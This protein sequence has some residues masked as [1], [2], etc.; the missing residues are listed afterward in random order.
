M[1]R[2]I[3]LGLFVAL[4]TVFTSLFAS[5]R[6]T[7]SKVNFDRDIRPILERSCYGCH[8]PAKAMSQLRLNDRSSGMRVI[9]PGNAKTSRLMARILGEGGEVQMPLGGPA[10]S[11]TDIELIRN[12]IDQ[13]ADWP[14]SPA[15]KKHWSFNAPTRD[16]LPAV[17]DR[18]WVKNPIDNFVLAKIE[19]HGLAPSPE[20]DRITLIR[21]LSLDL[22]GLPP[23]LEE[24]DRF[25]SDQDAK[26]YENLVERLLASPHYGERWGRHWL[27]VARYAD[28][29]GFEK[30]L[31]RSIWP[32]RDWVV[33]A[34]NRDMPFDQFTIEQLAGDL[35]PAPT[36][37]QR[38]AT[39]FLRNSMLNEEGAV[40][41]EQF[42]V[43]G[44]IDRVDAIGKAFLGLTINCAQCH[45]HK[46][47][48]IPQSDYYR[49]YAFLNSDDEPTLEVADPEVL[50]TRKEILD[51]IDKVQSDLLTSRPEVAAQFAG[52]EKSQ[53]QD[54]SSWTTIEDAS[55]TASFGTK[56]DRPPD[57]S[58]VAKGDNSTKNVY[59]I[60]ALSPL[61]RVT[62][63]RLELLT[64]P[65][66][67]RGGPGR[68]REGRLY[69]T[70]F[71]LDA[72]PADKASAAE[73]VAWES[74]TADFAGTSIADA[75]DGN[76]DTAWN[77][78]AGPGRRNQTRKAVF[79][80][81]RAVGFESGTNLT[82]YLSQKQEDGFNIGRFR[83]SVTDDAHPR[84]DR[85]PVAMR[86]IVSV[87]EASRSKDQKRD[88]F[89]YFLSTDE[90]YQVSSFHIDDLMKGWPYGPTT[91]VLAP[92]EVSRE[93]HIFKR[94]DW[95]RPGDVVRPGT[96]TALHPLPGGTPLNRLGLAQWIIDKQN[97]L[98]P[99]V[100][101]NRMWQEYFGVG[102]VTTPEDFGA[103]CESPS[104]PGLLDWLASEF[105][106]TGW[107]MKHIH[108]LIVS[109][110]TYRQSSKVTPRVQEADPTNVWLAR[111]PRL[112]V[113]AEIVHDIALSAG[114]LLNLKMGGPSVYPSIPDG[115]LNLG[116]GAP[117]RWETSTGAD[118][119]R[120]GMYTF[121]KRSVPYPS[122]L[123]FDEPN[124]DSSC[125]RRIRSNT[126]LQALTTLNDQ[127]F[128]EAAK[129]LGLRAWREG[130]TDDPSRV[131]YAFRLCTGRR[132]DEFEL[133]QL[134]KLL[135]EQ[136][137]YFVGKTG[138][139]VYVSAPDL[140][141]LPMDVDLHKVAPLTVVARVILNLD[142]TITRE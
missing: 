95:K 26:A 16:A 138:A 71:G 127:V 23:T 63:V 36:L 89:T 90:R 133:Q 113:D 67:P 29:N 10:L 129:G 62:G 134:M 114:G 101:V 66:L 128:V 107:S 115:V 125:T 122:L 8:G 69:L 92:R 58:F 11:P 2:S 24:I 109:S 137:P 83:L 106:D 110:A 17:K 70:E 130:G 15:T 59:V 4:I 6:Q 104:N 64:D 73:K 78:D 31:A 7:A 142:E 27:D 39:G 18:S 126:P 51:G 54:E 124:A 131:I 9:N 38:I 25:V 61:K 37:Q 32:Y 119:Y 40:D 44:I 72:S 84:A 12:W 91:L 116:F 117:M 123:V 57:H 94:G 68:S 41:P 3:K 141:N 65:S 97:P 105:R 118:R 102:L 52:W 74:A 48:P 98:T 100:I 93:T 55:I 47:D 111:A 13:G 112:R 132:P 121:W 46:F 140:N 22:T 86:R 60:K 139:S 35:L 19:E 103:R 56:F 75:I 80:T 135:E 28:T 53:T 1:T 33:D 14:A 21:R 88:L 136:K 45:S 34:M 49:F 120:R 77:I 42:R 20:A 87:P 99:R 43:E 5:A 85:L 81:K 30:D 79:V 108:R 82:F 76:L 96:P 50:A